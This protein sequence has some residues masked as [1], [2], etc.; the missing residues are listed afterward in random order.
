MRLD[1]TLLRAA[2]RYATETGQTLTALIEDGLRAVLAR[3][4]ARAEAKPVRLRTYGR[5][6]LQ[7]GVDLNDSAALRAAMEE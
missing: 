5:G 4:C 6:G 7:P 3:R 1:P 2:K